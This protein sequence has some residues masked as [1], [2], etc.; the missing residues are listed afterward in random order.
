MRAKDEIIKDL[1]QGHGWSC[2]KDRSL[3]QADQPFSMREAACIL[4][5]RD[6]LLEL[7]GK[8]HPGFGSR[9]PGNAGE[10][11]LIQNLRTQGQEDQL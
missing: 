8:P 9:L 2:L 7:L 4:K 3:G 5:L 1:T 10:D 11:S 6:A